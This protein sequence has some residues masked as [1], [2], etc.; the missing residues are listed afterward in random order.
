MTFVDDLMDDQEQEEQSPYPEAFGV[1]FT[2][3]VQGGVYA[4]LGIVGAAALAWYVVVPQWQELQTLRTTLNERQTQRDQLQASQA[5]ITELQGQLQQAQVD[6]AQV[7][8][9]FAPEDAFNTFLYTLSQRFDNRGRLLQYT[10][11]EDVPQVVQDSTWGTEVNGLI[12]R[13]TLSLQMEASFEQTMTILRDIERMQTLAALKNIRS[14]VTTQQQR[15]L[16]NQG[17]VNTEGEPLLTTSFD[18][19]L[20]FPVSAEELIEQN[21]AAAQPDP[22]APVDPNAPPVDPNAAGTPPQ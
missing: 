21:A 2:P 18:M 3:P 6:Q 9:L 11:P 16:T 17:S 19:E 4:F 14:E 10:P 1:Q 12:K 15:I 13:Q 20:L 5:R 7:L 22:N 8:S